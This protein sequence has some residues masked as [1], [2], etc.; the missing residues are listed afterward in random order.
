MTNDPYKVLGVS[1]SASDDDIKKAYR[2]LA[3]KYHPDQYE[4]N[5]LKDVAS[6]KM[7]EINAAYDAIMNERRGS[8]D[9]GFS[10]FGPGSGTNSHA[11][12]N[13]RVRNLIQSG[14]ITAAEQIL[15]GVAVGQRDAEWHFLRASVYYRRGWLNEA[16]S[17][18]ATAANMEPGN[19]EYAAAFRNM[20]SQQN[21][22]MAGNP[23]QQRNTSSMSGCDCCT[24]LCIADCCCECLGGDLIPCC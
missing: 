17:G 19:R 1:R 10:G 18:F 22:T 21:G 14:S 5:P 23:Y 15:D 8:A 4:D 20:Q 6:E 16:Y 7:E 24:S 12:D 11:F 9:Q 2:N 13:N 3:K